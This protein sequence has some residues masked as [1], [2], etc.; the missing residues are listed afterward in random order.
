MT[1]EMLLHIVSPGRIHDTSEEQDRSA[2][3]IANQIDE[4]TVGVEFRKKGSFA[5]YRRPRRSH[6]GHRDGFRSFLI[7]FD[8]GLVADL[9]EIQ[10]ELPAGANPEK[11]ALSAS[12]PAI[13]PIAFSAGRRS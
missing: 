12:K 7:H 4:R 9:P 10:R 2:H 11:S 1:V 6:A 13:I 3:V 5:P 8:D